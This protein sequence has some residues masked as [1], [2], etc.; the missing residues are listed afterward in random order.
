VENLINIAG[1]SPESGGHSRAVGHKATSLNRPLVCKQRRETCR[2][3]ECRHA[4]VFAGKQTVRKHDQ[5]ADLRG[6]DRGE[7]I[8]KLIRRPRFG[9]VKLD[10]ERWRRSLRLLEQSEIARVCRIQQ[11]GDACEARHHLAQ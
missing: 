6:T 2:C 7:C 11:D 1:Q 9:E 3:G 4:R 8:L 5:S 10:V